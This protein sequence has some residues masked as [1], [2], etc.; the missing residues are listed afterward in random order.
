MHDVDNVRDEKNV[1]LYRHEIGWA[2][3]AALCTT[4]AAPP[5]GALTR[6]GVLVKRLFNVYLTLI[7][8][9]SNVILTKFKRCSNVISTS[10]SSKGMSL[11][12]ARWRHKSPDSHTTIK[13]SEPRWCL[14]DVDTA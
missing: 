10:L 2:L 13:P 7:K 1:T 4:C 9:R 11:R 12:F 6:V 5:P 14:K 3:R 8:R